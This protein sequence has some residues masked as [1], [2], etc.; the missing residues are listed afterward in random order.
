MAGRIQHERIV[1]R[2]GSSIDRG[3]VDWIQ[4]EALATGAGKQS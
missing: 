4:L 2:A 1:P 3:S